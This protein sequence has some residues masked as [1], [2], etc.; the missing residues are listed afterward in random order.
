MGVSGDIR[1]RVTISG[2]VQGVGFRDALRQE[3]QREHVAGWVR[4]RD[5]GLV[6][7]V[8]EGPEAR[9]A[10]VLGYCHVG[11]RG[12]RVEAVTADPEPP[13]ALRG[14]RIYG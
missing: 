2:L 7:A 14:F 13:A 5:D 3:A 8:L 10:R 4:N 1:L 9:V 11:P 6:E 12:A